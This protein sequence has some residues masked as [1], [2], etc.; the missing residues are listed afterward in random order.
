MYLHDEAQ[1]EN[2]RDLPALE[3]HRIRTKCEAIATTCR[4]RQTY[5][6]LAA[7]ALSAMPEPEAQSY[8]AAME[9]DIASSVCAWDQLA[10]NC[11]DEDDRQNAVRAA[12]TGDRNMLLNL[13]AQ[14]A[15]DA[16][17]ENLAQSLWA[18]AED[19][20]DA[21]DRA[22]DAHD[23]LEALAGRKGAFNAGGTWYWAQCGCKVDQEDYNCLIHGL[24]ASDR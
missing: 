4:A 2:L 17:R 1:P 19:D 22:A 18:M 8:F 21:A 9:L 20:D 12:L 13:A 5:Y 6:A 15:R 14:L 23:P 11:N 16:G 3:L 7:H 10:A 24:H